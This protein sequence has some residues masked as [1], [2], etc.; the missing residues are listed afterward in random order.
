MI[1]YIL[2]AFSKRGLAP[3]RFTCRHAVPPLLPPAVLRFL[4]RAA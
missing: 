2:E 3:A 4:H 1:Q